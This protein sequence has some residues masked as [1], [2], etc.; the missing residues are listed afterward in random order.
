MDTPHEYISKL[1]YSPELL[2]NVP[3]LWK[4]CSLTRTHA[5]THAR[6]DT[7]NLIVAPCPL[8]IQL[9][10]P[11]PIYSFFLIPLSYFPIRRGFP[12]ILYACFLRLLTVWPDQTHTPRVNHLKNDSQIAFE[13][14][15]VNICTTWCNI[16]KL[17]MSPHSTSVC[18][19]SLILTINRLFS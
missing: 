10:D 6:T 14:L 5:R 1:I 18:L 4:I 19:F 11:L 9:L 2:S 17:R 16:R 8:P 15:M 7:Q 3:P 13:D 12:D